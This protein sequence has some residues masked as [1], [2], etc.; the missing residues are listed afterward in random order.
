MQCDSVHWRFEN[1]ELDGQSLA[2]D[3]IKSTVNTGNPNTDWCHDIHRQRAHAPYNACV[4]TQVT[5][6]NLTVRNCW[7]HD[8]RLAGYLGSPDHVQQ[9]INL[10]WAH[11][12]IEKT[13]GYGVFKAQ[14][15]R[16]GL[17]LDDR[18]PGI[19]QWGWLIKDNVWMRTSPPAQTGRPNLLVDAPARPAA[20]AAPTWRRSRETWSWPNQL[21]PRRTMPSRVSGNLRVVNNILMKTTPG[22]F[23]SGSSTTSR[24]LGRLII[25]NTVFIDGIPAVPGCQRAAGYAGHRQQR[26]HTRKR[27]IAV[28]VLAGT[29][30]TNNIVPGHR[31]NRGSDDDH[32]ADQPDLHRHDG[33][34]H[35]QLLP[36]RR[37]A[38]DADAQDT[39]APAFD[40]N[41]AARPQGAA[42]D[43]RAYELA[44]T[45]AAQ[46][47]IAFKHPGLTG[48]TDGAA[49][50]TWST[51]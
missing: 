19:H 51:C 23:G 8:S 26:F 4:N 29:V 35:R 47:G 38:A 33:R 22:P 34:R 39:Y 13:Y 46:S 25:N 6:W 5:V 15:V 1:L 18:G 36:D 3:G 9:I 10:V 16:T 42:A 24:T 31:R 50:W 14:N 37:L 32:H 40:F 27:A 44:A 11:N 49:T 12:L 30:V 21:T 7:L 48:D 20:S 2:D 28:S 45:P 17:T 41:G 43:V